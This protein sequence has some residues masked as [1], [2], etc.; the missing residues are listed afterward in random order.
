MEMS[1]SKESRAE[2]RVQSAWRSIR[3]WAVAA[4]AA[5][6]L[7]AGNASAADICISQPAK[8]NLS[9]CPG[10]KMEATA[11]KKPAVSFNS[12]PQGV[13][14]KKRDD[15]TKPTLPTT[16]QSI[17]QRDERRNRLEARS[18]QLLVT[19]IQG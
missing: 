18:R 2:L 15:Q 16:S 17:A 5:S 4:V 9:Q 7:A 3:A 1:E 8:D 10:G 14:L 19:E 6:A 11:G 13:N 12:A